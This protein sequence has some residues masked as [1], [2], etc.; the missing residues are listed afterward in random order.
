MLPD[1]SYG[2]CRHLR[3]NNEDVQNYLKMRWLT[4][5]FKLIK[6]FTEFVHDFTQLTKMVA[7][8]FLQKDVHSPLLPPVAQTELT[9][10][11]VFKWV[12]DKKALLI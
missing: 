12:Q 6:H 10:I 1:N 3:K 8:I 9:K 5:L 11:R 4:S 7:V 2:F